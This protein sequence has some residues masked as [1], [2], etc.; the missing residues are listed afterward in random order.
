MAL[1]LKSGIYP[2]LWPLKCPKTSKN[3]IYQDQTR[4]GQNFMA[5]TFFHLDFSSFFPLFWGGF[6]HMARSVNGLRGFY[7]KPPVGQRGDGFSFA[8][9]IL[10]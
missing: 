9:D 3:S 7:R 5:L 4:M 2:K 10:Y 8:V 6:R 1:F